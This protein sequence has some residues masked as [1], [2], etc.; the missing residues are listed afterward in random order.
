MR[1]R[2]TAVRCTAA[3]HQSRYMYRCPSSGTS[4]P[5]RAP[6]TAADSSS[7]TW[8]E[9][10]DILRRHVFTGVFTPEERRER[11]EQHISQL[12]ERLDGD[13]DER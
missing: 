5:C 3:L 12:R 7:T 9:A 6:Y 2:A 4:R 13:G 8:E 11:F 1:A 10:E